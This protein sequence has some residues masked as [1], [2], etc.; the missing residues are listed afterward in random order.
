MGQPRL[1]LFIFVRFN[2]KLYRKTV[3]I[4]GI[5]TRIVGVEGEHADHL[6]ITTAKYFDVVYI[7]LFPM[8]LLQNLGFK[9]GLS[10]KG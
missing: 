7:Y 2:H 8:L 1:F 3:G 5:G 10:Q 6:T 4:S 9:F